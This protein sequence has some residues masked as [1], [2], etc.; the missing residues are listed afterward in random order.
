[1]EN[2]VR[3]LSTEAGRRAIER[4]RRPACRS[5]R[6]LRVASISGTPVSFA[7]RRTTGP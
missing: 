6:R 5:G 3:L 4:A 2:G 7:V 1:V